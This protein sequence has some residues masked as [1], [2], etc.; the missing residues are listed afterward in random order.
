MLRDA[1]YGLRETRGEHERER[2]REIRSALKD[3]WVRQAGRL[4]DSSL[5][6]NPRVAGAFEKENRGKEE[7]KERGGKGGR[8]RVKVA[9]TRLS[10]PIANDKP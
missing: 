1:R 9:Q 10:R 2:E 4:K 3:N 7:E 5:R 6:E 8:A